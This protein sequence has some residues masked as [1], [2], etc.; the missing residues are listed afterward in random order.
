[1]REHVERSD[2]PEGR[3]DQRDSQAVDQLAED[4]TPGSPFDPEDVLGADAAIRQLRPATQIADGRLV[5]DLGRI[6]EQEWAD[7][8]DQD[9]G[10]EHDQRKHRDLVATETRPDDLSEAATDHG[11]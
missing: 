2:R 10:D 6:R 11:P 7:D 9:E 1:M 4:V 8:R 5:E 3:D